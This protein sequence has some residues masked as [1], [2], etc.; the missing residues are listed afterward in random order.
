MCSFCQY[1]NVIFSEDQ[2]QNLVF[3]FFCKTQLKENLRWFL[4]PG[5]R[6]FIKVR[7]GKNVYCAE[8]TILCDFL[9]VFQGK[10]AFFVQDPAGVGS[11]H[12]N[13][14][15]QGLACEMPV[16][17]QSTDAFPELFLYVHKPVF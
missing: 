15:T 12:T 4:L 6:L 14:I 2:L 7:I 5:S 16:R 9:N 13:D 11:I 1:F 10:I 17:H 3:F 8:P